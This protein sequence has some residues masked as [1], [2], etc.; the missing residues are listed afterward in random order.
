[1][2]ELPPPVVVVEPPLLELPVVVPPVDIAVPASQP[3]PPPPQ[4]IG[5]TRSQIQ[6][7]RQLSSCETRRPAP[8]MKWASGSEVPRIMR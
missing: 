6:A 5:A 1:V 2:V 4:A 8:R 7:S 3:P